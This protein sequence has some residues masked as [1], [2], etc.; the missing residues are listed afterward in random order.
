MK[1]NGIE[2]NIHYPRSIYRQKAYADEFEG[3]EFPITDRICEE[4]LSLP[5]FPGMSRNQAEYVVKMVNRFP[6]VV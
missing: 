6:N 5:I 2:T 4:E 1:E 3:Q